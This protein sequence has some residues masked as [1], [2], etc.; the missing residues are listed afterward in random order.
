MKKEYLKKIYNENNEYTNEELNVLAK[1]TTNIEKNMQIGKKSALTITD[2]FATIFEYA[3]GNDFSLMVNE[4][5]YAKNAAYK[6]AKVGSYRKELFNLGIEPEIID[7][8]GVGQLIEVLVLDVELVADLIL[9]DKITSDMSTKDIRNYVK[10]FNYLEDTECYEESEDYE[11]S[12]ESKDSTEESEESEESEETEETTESIIE[13]AEKRMND[14][15]DSCPVK[16][17]KKE[18]EHITKLLN[19]E[20]KA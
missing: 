1:S 16:M 6:Y 4:I 2:E 19:K 9:Q 8:F 20:I 13:K 10:N 11:E 17:T 5:G 3:K 7:A 12:E 14:W 18:R 15:L